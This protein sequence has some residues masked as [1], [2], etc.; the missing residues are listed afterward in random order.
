MALHV[1]EYLMTEEEYLAFEEKSQVRHEYL[2]GTIHAMVGGTRAHNGIA[3][4][5]A[6]ALKEQ[7]KGGPCRVFMTDIKVKVEKE[8]SYYYPDVVVT[9]DPRE[10]KLDQGLA[11]EHPSLVVEVLSPT[12]AYTDE[13]EKWRAY[14]TLAS[15]QEYVLVDS[16]KLRATI[17]RRAQVGWIRIELDKHDSLTLESVPFSLRLMELYE[18]VELPEDSEET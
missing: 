17:H 11:L 18:G 6:S 15:L 5:L 14:Q 9:C 8:Q 3:L 12:T 2:G 16:R 10:A 13:R 4:N 1:F 7:L